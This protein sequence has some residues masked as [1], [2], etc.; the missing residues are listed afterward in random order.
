MSVICRC[1][2]PLRWSWQALV[3]LLGR[4]RRPSAGLALVEPASTALVVRPSPPRPRVQ[5]GVGALAVRPTQSLFGVGEDPPYLPLIELSPEFLTRLLSATSPRTLGELFPPFLQQYLRRPDLQVLNPNWPI[6]ARLT[7]ALQSGASA[8]RVLDGVFDKQ[9]RAPGLPWDNR[10]YVV[11]RCQLHRGG[12]VTQFYSVYTAVLVDQTG[13][14][15]A[16]S[17]SHGFPTASEVEVF[18]RGARRQW[19]PKLLPHQL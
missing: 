5:R 7:R 13:E 12:F 17:V 15:E 11:L 6:E 10:F 4:C 3:H 1:L 8:R 18:L 14:L 2:E 19:P 9:V 16:G